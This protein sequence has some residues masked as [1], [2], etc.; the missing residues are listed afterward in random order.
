MAKK[1]SSILFAI[2]MV[3]LVFIGFA[4]VNTVEASSSSWS[5][6]TNTVRR[7]IR[8]DIRNDVR[9]EI[10]RDISRWQREQR[11]IIR[12]DGDARFAN[13]Y[14]NDREVRALRILKRCQVGVETQLFLMSS[15]ITAIRSMCSYLPEFAFV[16][17]I[18]DQYKE[19][20]GCAVYRHPLVEYR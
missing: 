14:L 10:R 19:T 3:M 5:R 18:K 8:R 6:W 16:G 11:N 9:R 12:A 1:I 7:D 20:L 13:R 4:N 2:S 17:L 15:D